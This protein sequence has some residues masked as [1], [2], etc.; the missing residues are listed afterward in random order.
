MTVIQELKGAIGDLRSVHDHLSLRVVQ[1]GERWEWA[2]L[3][4]R[5]QLQVQLTRISELAR[6][7]APLQGNEEQMRNYRDAF[8]RMRTAVALHQASWPV[9]DI[10]HREQAYLDSVANARA[11]TAAFFAAAEKALAEIDR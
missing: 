11:A 1:G 4:L 2:V 8:S 6:T 3:D 9:V 5:R 10:S 7:C